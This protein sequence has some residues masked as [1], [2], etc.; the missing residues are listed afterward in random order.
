[1]SLNF[2]SIWSKMEEC[3]SIFQLE[4]SDP[5]IIHAIETWLNPTS[6]RERSYHPN[7]N[8]QLVGA[9]PAVF[10]EGFYHHQTERWDASGIPLQSDAEIVASSIP[11]PI[12]ICSIYRPT[13]N[14]LC[15]TPTISVSHCRKYTPP[16]RKYQDRRRHKPARY[17][18][19]KWHIWTSLLANLLLT[20]LMILATKR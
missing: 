2:Q 14:N 10:I 19:E 8:L 16:T 18:M 6:K 11:E 15:Y 1:M 9:A 17:Q 3:W 5:E 13:N 20:F 7:T 4:Y 12:V